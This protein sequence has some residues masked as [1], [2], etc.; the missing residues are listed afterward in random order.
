VRDHGIEPILE[1]ISLSAIGVSAGE[2]R[3][4]PHSAVPGAISR[5]KARG[6]RR[7]Q[8]EACNPRRLRACPDMHRWLS[9]RTTWF[10]L[11]SS[12]RAPSCVGWVPSYTRF[13]HNVTE[14]GQNELLVASHIKPWKDVGHGER[15]ASSNGLLLNVLH[16]KA[17]DRGLITVTDDLEVALSTGLSNAPLKS[18]VESFFETY[19]NQEITIPRS[20]L[21]RLNLAFLKWMAPR[22]SLPEAFQ[23]VESRLQ[24]AG[25]CPHPSR[26]RPRWPTPG[27]S[28]N[29]S[30][31]SRSPR[32]P[33]SAR[34]SMPAG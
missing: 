2:D 19:E 33:P 4:C 3:R 7:Y 9:I 15:I 24:E 14:I 26:N 11:R 30:S 29:G 16:H 21:D 1:P 5:G 6:L 25:L 31:R 27:P 17:F 22:E 34:R 18:A 10:G 23:S 12:C 20:E 8:C 28:T 13:L 32:R